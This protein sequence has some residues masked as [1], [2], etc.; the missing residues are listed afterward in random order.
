MLLKK[1]N[2]F[3]FDLYALLIC[4]IWVIG[5]TTVINLSLEVTLR[6]RADSNPAKLLGFRTEEGRSFT[7]DVL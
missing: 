5:N 6:A 1:Q 2:S 7:I 3:W 4:Q